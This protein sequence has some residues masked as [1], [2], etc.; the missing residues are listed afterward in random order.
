MQLKILCLLRKGLKSKFMINIPN[1]TEIQ[2]GGLI[3]S[4]KKYNDQQIDIEM[5][6]QN[7]KQSSTQISKFVELFW[8]ISKVPNN[9]KLQ[10]ELELITLSYNLTHGNIRIN[11]YSNIRDCYH[12]GS[13]FINP[14]KVLINAALYPAGIYE[15]RYCLNN[16]SKI[17]PIEQLYMDYNLEEYPWQSELVKMEFSK[18]NDKI[19]IKFIKNKNEYIYR[20]TLD[21]TNMLNMA[22]DNILKN[23]ALM[24]A[25]NK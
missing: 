14:K 5:N 16:G 15:I 9:K 19:S 11:G 20:C 21:Q 2:I 3:R 25:Y 22:F 17:Y 24:T 1:A 4:P 13:L 12:S 23:G 18:I 6:D 10:N 8:F 7:I